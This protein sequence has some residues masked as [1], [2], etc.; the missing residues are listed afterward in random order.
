MVHRRTF[1]GSSLF[2]LFVIGIASRKGTRSRPSRTGFSGWPLSRWGR[3]LRMGK[4]MG[5]DRD[6][7]LEG[8]QA[9]GIYVL[10]LYTK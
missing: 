5:G 6:C 1:L 2:V 7:G 10:Y 8:R 4:R 9:G 3:R